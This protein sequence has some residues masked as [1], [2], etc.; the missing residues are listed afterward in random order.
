MQTLP[1]QSRTKSI[2]QLVLGA[3]LVMVPLVLQLVFFLKNGTSS[4]FFRTLMET[5]LGPLFLLFI[6]CYAIGMFTAYRGLA[7][8]SYEPGHAPA[9]A[10]RKNRLAWLINILS[11]VMFI[12][13]SMTEWRT[14]AVMSNLETIS[15]LV[16]TM[17]IGTIMHRRIYPKHSWST[18]VI[19]DPSLAS[20]DERENAILNQAGYHAL[21]ASFILMGLIMLVML[22]APKPS[23]LA[24]VMFFV[25]VWSIQ[26]GLYGFFAW[27]AGLR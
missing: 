24:V 20:Q 11:G 6:A 26:R 19:G 12:T 2:T 17:T 23:T 3:T 18:A 15:L 16:V 4:M 27:R 14:T 10:D 21:A 13:L 9:M 5:L 22:L 25:G 7:N 1:A 8:L